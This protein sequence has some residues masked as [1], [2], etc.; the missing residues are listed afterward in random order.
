MNWL[1]LGLWWTLLDV[2]FNM[3]Y[4]QETFNPT[5]LG[6]DFT[7]W[8]V[9]GVIITT[10]FVFLESFFL[11]VWRKGL[12]A[13]VAAF[14]QYKYWWYFTTLLFVRL[15]S[16]GSSLS[17]WWLMNA[18]NLWNDTI[19]VLYDIISIQVGCNAVCD[20]IHHSTLIPVVLSK[21]NYHKY[22][23]FPLIRLASLLQD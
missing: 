4:Y 6:K 13:Y 9:N 22:F 14:K 23:S 17:S 1:N 5:T 3:S 2:S 11:Y 20:E 15:G 8:V 18:L 21:L 16:I 19:S 10:I 7:N 12:S